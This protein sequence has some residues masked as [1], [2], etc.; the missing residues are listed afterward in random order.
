VPTKLAQD[1]CACLLLVRTY[2]SAGCDDRSPNYP[3]RLVREVLRDKQHVREA[4]DFVLDLKSTCD[5]SADD[6][7]EIPYRVANG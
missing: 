2:I 5:P 7:Q 4:E 1:P 6:V 3:R